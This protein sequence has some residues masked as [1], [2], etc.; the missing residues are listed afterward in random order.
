[1][2][3]N[4]KIYTLHNVDTLHIKL[5]GAFDGSSA[6]ELINTIN[7]N[8]GK[9]DKIVV[10][11]TALSIIHPFGRDIFQHHFSIKKMNSDLRFIGQHEETISPQNKEIEVA[12][13]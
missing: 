5:T 4:F 6:C 2:A 7:S 13:H 11:T 1:M 9:V 8:N 3:S 12:G 10:N